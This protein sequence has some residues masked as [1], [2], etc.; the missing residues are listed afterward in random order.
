[1]KGAELVVEALAAE[2][3]RQVY[4]IPGTTIMDVLDVFAQQDRIRYLSVRHEQVAAFMAD[5]FSRASGE[6]GVCIGSRG[7]GAA[8]MATA[9][10]NAWDESVPLVAL[11]GSV[12]HDIAE[13]DAF[14][15]M[16]LMSVFRPITKWSVEVPSAARIPELVQRAVR[17]A[18]Q[19]RPGPVV[20]SLPLSVLTADA[21][22]STLPVSRAGL[23]R[24]AAED[25]ARAVQLLR[26]AEAPTIV[27][28][29]G[30]DGGWDSALT[31]L[32][33][34]TGAAVV[35]TWSR[36]DRFPNAH[37]AFLG[38]LGAGALA[39]SDDAVR[40]ADVLLALGCRFSEFTTKRWT[41]VQPRTRIVQVDID[42]EQIGKI[43]PVAVGLHA[44]AGLAAADL[45][46]ALRA[47]QSTPGPTAQA[48]AARL[49]RLRAEH[50]EQ[51]T[52]PGPDPATPTGT[53]PSAALT[54]ALRTLVES[55][56][57]T[58]VVDAPSTGVWVSRFIDVPRPGGYVASAGGAM[59]WGFPAAL[60]MALARPE[61]RVV[62]LSGDGSFWMVAQDLETAVRERIP[63]VTVVANNS[64]YGNTRDRQRSAHGGRYFGVFYDNP[65][66]AAFARLHGAHGERVTDA[67][68]LLPALHR[69]LDSGLPAI[70]DVVQ[71]P[72][73][74]LPPGIRPLPPR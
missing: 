34:L 55:R 6:V 11:V 36:K 57:L 45:V 5:G 7:P 51:T 64:A 20:V 73:E 52:M 60:G 32:A 58:L 37:P 67:A 59:A 53:V 23:P 12:A 15:E 41:L 46:G 74:G 9:I 42:V 19:G 54:G 26:G 28:G 62:C 14:E 31:E 44:D 25:V 40:D 10:A 21:D 38:A 39:V 49:D 29:G 16:D 71:G 63:V 13:R 3:V 35:T 47:G 56:E 18:R 66:L 22:V 1:M 2:G 72:H 68:E 69:A 50:A 30:V 27:V 33:D 48:R 4:G 8:N 43:H 61:Q 65:D 70:V 17:T 24:P